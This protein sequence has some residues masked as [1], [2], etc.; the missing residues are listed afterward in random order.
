M[1][2]EDLQAKQRFTELVSRIKQNTTINPFEEKNTQRLRIQK[3]KTDYAFFVSYYFPHLAKAPC[4]QF[5]ISNANQTKSKPRLKRVVQWARGHAKST[6]FGVFIPLWLKVQDSKDFNFM[7]L[8]GKSQNLACE[9]LGNLQAELQNNQRYIHDFGE[10]LQL[11]TWEDGRFSTKDDCSFVALGRGQS[12]RGLLYKGNR[13]DYIVLDD[14]DDD[15]IVLNP[16]RMRKLEDWTLEALYPAMAYGRGR[17]IAVGNKIHKESLIARIE[18]NPEFETTKVNALDKNGAPSW[19][20]NYSLEEINSMIAVMGERRA[21]KELFNNPSISEGEIFKAD[22]I[23]HKPM[24]PLNK[25][26]QLV[27]YCD[28]SFKN[29]ATSDF[30]AVVLVGRTKNEFHIIDSLIRRCSVSEMANYFFDLQ[31]SMPSSINCEFW[32]EAN[33]AQDLLLQEFEKIEKSRNTILL[34]RKDTR[35]KP[36]KFGR[37]ENLSPLFERKMVYFNEKNKY[38]SDFSTLQDQL[39]SF[40]RGSRTPDDGPDALEGA[41][42]ILSKGIANNRNTYRIGKIKNQYKY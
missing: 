14:V 29:S 4:A 27:A 34:L 23:Q 6:H 18:N 11:G 13:P 7:V 37:I 15:E 19:P 28:P 9:H 36:D 39:L 31:D 1:K 30:K 10:Q 20:E 24:L 5:Q 40:E 26:S 33:F 3:A 21:Q 25:Y 32:I 12:P 2:R 16:K 17:F 35:K 42:Y 22:H 38:K 8:V 41:L